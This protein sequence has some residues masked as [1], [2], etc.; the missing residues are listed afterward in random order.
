M[1]LNQLRRVGRL[2][3][4]LAAPRFGAPVITRA[5]T[6]FLLETLEAEPAP[7]V[8]AALLTPD[9]SRRFPLQVHTTSRTPTG[10]G[11]SVV[12][13]VVTAAEAP[14]GGYDLSLSGI[15]SAPEVA[16]RSVWLRA[17]DPDAPAALHL[18]HVTD[19]HVGSRGRAGARLEHVLSEINDHAPDL[20]LITGDIANNGDRAQHYP[21]AVRL[22]ST[23][24]APSLIVAG[25][26]DHGFSPRAI[27]GRGFGAGFHNFASAFHPFLH[28][29]LQLAGWDFIGFDSGPSRLSPLVRTRGLDAE[30]L[31]ALARDL[32]S[33][34]ARGR[35][36]VVLFSHTPLRSR[37]TGSRPSA[38]PGLVGGMSRGSRA[39]EELLRNA[40]RRGQRVLHLAGHTHWM[41]VFELD[42]EG[43]RFMRWDHRRIG[44]EGQPITTPVAPVALVNTQSASH[45][46][47]P[48]KRNGLGY[49]FVRIVLDTA[50]APKIHFHR[51]EALP[52]RGR[53]PAGI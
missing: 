48:L 41:E 15:G 23:L 43:K 24:R 44:A 18:A 10:E 8:T 47:I 50:E 19:L 30:A 40:A 14:P 29:G 2:Q 52:S 53:L 42:A 7:P 5:G 49:G 31:A 39:F 17:S 33:A 34:H 28:F 11:L 1:T 22:L 9:G 26:H 20:V 37:L 38:L 25:N 51:Y 36:G 45:S 35:R 13:R 32:D 6:S 16:P 12:H 4:G 27:A 21:S 46:G 3:P